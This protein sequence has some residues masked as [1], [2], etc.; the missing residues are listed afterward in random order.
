MVRARKYEI[1]GAGFERDMPLTL[2]GTPPTKEVQKLDAA[3]SA[4]KIDPIMLTSAAAM[5]LTAL[6]RADSRD[7]VRVQNAAAVRILEGRMG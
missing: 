2:A 5:V 6:T 7:A 3:G 4:P 1:E